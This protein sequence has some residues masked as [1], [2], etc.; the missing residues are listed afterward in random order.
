VSKNRVQI[1][2]VPNPSCSRRASG[3]DDAWVWEKGWVLLII[4]KSNVDYQQN[5]A[6]RPMRSC[7]YF[8]SVGAGPTWGQVSKVRERPF[9]ASMAK[10]FS[11]KLL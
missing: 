10:R 2:A 9:G 8:R 3:G 6:T 11:R 4:N 7:V 1:L 5:M